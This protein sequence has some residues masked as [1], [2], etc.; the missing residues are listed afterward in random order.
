MKLL[1]KNNLD[2]T[3][4]Y[5]GLSVSVSFQSYLRSFRRINYLYLLPIVAVVIVVSLP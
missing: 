5:L 4:E 3:L 2:I 1:E